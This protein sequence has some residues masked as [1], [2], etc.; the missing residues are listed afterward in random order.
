VLEG[1]NADLSWLDRL[2]DQV[3]SLL[4]STQKIG[5]QS[6]DR[7]VISVHGIRT[8]GHW[9]DNLGSLVESYSRHCD[10][11][12]IKFGFFNVF[13]FLIP[14][15]RKLVL[16]RVS[17][18]ISQNMR[19]HEDK[20]VY[21]VA[22]SFGTV[23]VHEALRSRVCGKKLKGIIL[24]G[25]PLPADLNIDHIVRNSE[26][27]YNEC[28]TRD[29]VLVMARLFGWG[30]GDAGRIG[31]LR[32]NTSTFR[33]RYFKGGHGLYFD[34]DENGVFFYERQWLP[35]LIFGTPL[36]SQDFRSSYFG[37]DLVDLLL[38]AGAF[39]KPVFYLL[40]PIAV[41]VISLFRIRFRV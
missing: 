15:L 37:Q 35:L 18:R 3:E 32:E 2:V 25:S 14:F 4:G 10:R 31:F 17:A 16:K 41:F 19:E 24:C 6:K 36:S 33:N 39:L 21:L 8:Y 28:G 13:F 11:V 1:T 7:V 26:V 9:Q 20:E 30:L 38:N 34:K 27:T 22:H 40:A 12:E 5:N 29:F 23:A